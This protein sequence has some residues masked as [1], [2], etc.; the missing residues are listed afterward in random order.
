MKTITIRSS[1]LALGLFSAGTVQALTFEE[2]EI[3]EVFV[4]DHDLAVTS[5]YTNN[6]AIIIDFSL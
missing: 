4:V 6:S 3:V 2:P 1:I 5:Y